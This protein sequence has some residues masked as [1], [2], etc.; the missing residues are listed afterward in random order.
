MLFMALQDD[1]AVLPLILYLQKRISLWNSSKRLYF[2]AVFIAFCITVAVPK[3][4]TGYSNLEIFICSMAELVFVGNAIS[5]TMLLWIKYVPFNQFIEKMTSL[6]KYYYQLPSVREYLVQFNRR[7]HRYTNKYCAFI[8]ILIVFYCVAPVATSFGLYFQTLGTSHNGYRAGDNVSEVSRPVVE[9]NL[10][11]EQGFFGLQQRTNFVHYLL[12]TSVILPM[13]FTTAITV[14]TKLLTI[15]SSVRYCEALLHVLTFKVN[16]LHLIPKEAA[17]EQL[18][19]IIH[20]HQ[21]TLDAIALMVQAFRP[22]LLLQLV[23][24]ICIWCLMMLYFTIAEEMNVK[25]IN[26][27]I[28]FFVLTVETFGQCYVGTRLSN[29]ANELTKA[30]YACGW[31]DMELDVQQGVQMILHRTQWPIGIQAG[32]FCYVDM[33]CFQ[34]A[35]KTMVNMSYSFFIVL[36]DAF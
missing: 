30:V 22:V 20:T 32:K 36:K 24:C 17:R 31:Q 19:D 13:M 18:R 15:C 29:Q 11:M 26:I 6:T 9:F 28:L 10:H 8:A 14:H 3:L 2:P 16:S 7:I 12:F 34:K 21:R 5:G 27:A 1:R 33:E 4:V 23:F 25:F 35:S